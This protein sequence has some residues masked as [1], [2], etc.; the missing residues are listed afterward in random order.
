VRQPQVTR[1]PIRRRKAPPTPSA[2]GPTDEVRDLRAGIAALRDE[3]ER[4]RAMESE[5]IQKAAAAAQAEIVSLRETVSALRDEMDGHVQRGGEE[6]DR[7]ESGWQGRLTE[8]QNT[9][10]AL[11]ERLEELHGTPRA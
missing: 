10:V 3:L 6:R 9:I 7:R 4:S 2:A 11:R 1:R 5:R 8:A